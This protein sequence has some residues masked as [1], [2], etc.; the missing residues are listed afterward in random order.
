MFVLL[1][2][3][4]LTGCAVFGQGAVA[5][6]E[7]PPVPARV[8]YVGDDG[9]VYVMPLAAGE[10]QGASEPHYPQRVSQ[11]TGKVE[12]EPSPGWEAPT[13]RWPTWAP[14]GSRLAFVRE[15]LGTGELL[16]A[17][18]VWVVGHDGA[19]PRKLWEATDRQPIYLAWAP[20]GRS[21][22]MLV[23]GTTTMDLV[24]LDAVGDA[25]PRRL[26]Q[27]SPFYFVWAADSRSLLLH[28]GSGSAQPA[29]GILRLGPPDEFRSLGIVPGDF[30]TPGWSADGR[31]IAFVENGPG[32][33]PTLSLVSPEGGDITRLATGFGLIAFLLTPDGTRV[34]WSSHST[35]DR[36]AYDGLEVL[37]A[38]GKR[39]TRVTDALVMAFFWS[40]DARQLAYVTQERGGQQ[41]AWHVADA[42][43]AN[44]RRLATFIPTF[45]QVRLLA[46]FDQYAISHGVWSPDG[47]A[48]VQA[49]GLPGE[50]RMFGR[51]G[52]GTVQAVPL[53]GEVSAGEVRARTLGGGTF[54]ALP[55]PAP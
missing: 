6:P 8:A 24:L 27:G 28:V 47:S 40:P 54:A 26:A 49:F 19:E 45:E 35:T 48:L 37:S 5:P 17:A 51:S 34:A 52:P 21:I 20:D 7:R 13:G 4:L 29:L 43:G 41:L 53:A 12:G 50:P 36:M 33:A 9:H 25:S 39:R 31:T 55:V 46:F 14:D 42:D 1:A 10:S 32:G 11:I 30:R 16:L 44:S 2:C 38:D 18:Q 22:A 23:E 15:L 3:L